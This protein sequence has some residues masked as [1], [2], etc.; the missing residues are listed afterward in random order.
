MANYEDAIRNIRQNLKEYLQKSGLKSLVIG[1]SGGL[2]ST[3]CCA[4]AHPVCQEL[5]IKLIGRS[6][7]IESNKQ[8]EIERARMVG[9]IFCTDFSEHDLTKMYLSLR[10]AVEAKEPLGDMDKDASAEC[11]R[12][13]KI[14]RGNIK[15]RVRM[16]YLYNLAQV[17]GGMVLSTDNLTELRLGFWTLHGDVGDYGMIQ[18]CTKTEVYNI[19]EH[20][21]YT[22]PV[23]SDERDTLKASIEGI[24]TDGLG[25]TKSDLDQILPG[26]ENKF[27]CCRDGYKEVDRIF[28]V[29]FELTKSIQ[30]MVS[31]DLEEV[32]RQRKHPVIERYIRTQFKRENPISISR[33]IIFAK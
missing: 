31:D 3:A 5:G 26:W 7:T 32:L 16:I 2:D 24:P 17:T 19:V 22:Y 6:L 28:D 21:M 20:I 23:G 14:R 9:D 30:S 12:A 33:D 4:L 1:V 11:I 8:E 13:I 27:A 29:Y 18:N 15:A 25:I 10:A